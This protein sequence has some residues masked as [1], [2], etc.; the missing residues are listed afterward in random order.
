MKTKKIIFILSLIPFG[1]FAQ[2]GYTIQGKIP[3]VLKQPTKIFLEYRDDTTH[4]L[5]STVLDNGNFIFK[6]HLSSPSAVTLTV[7][8]NP[9]EPLY[10]QKDGLYFY[11]ENSD[12]SIVSPDS[13]KD[14]IVKGSQTNDDDIVLHKI[15]RPY[16]Q[17]ADSITKVYYTLTPEQRK[18]S[19]FKANAGK[20]M[21]I[22]QH[23][24]DSATRKFI[25]SHLNSYVSLEAFKE[26][27]LAYNFN[28]DTA[29]PK[30]DKFSTTLKES[31]LGKKIQT[32]INKNKATMMGRIAPDF[33][34][35]DTLGNLVRLSD[36]RG[37]YVLLDFW[38]SWCHPCRAENPNLIAAYKK[39]KDDNFTILSVSLDEAKTRSAWVNAVRYDSLPW[40]QI[41]ELTGFKSKAAVLYAVEAIPVNFL[42]DPSGKIIAR[43]LRGEG[44]DE[45]LSTLF[46]K[47]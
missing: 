11:I 45:K 46:I 7:Q 27:E 16:R 38:A 37:H 3:Y 32:I 18:D 9:N 36:F 28:P 41:S 4:V 10:K 47:K 24:Y 40:T 8:N 25:Y 43:N 13:L 6:G 20:I 2:K 14:A 31:S 42:L 22:T 19:A 23:D 1:G 17:V 34:E 35:K 26:V 15:Q 21:A 39:Y 33:A 29:Q 30:F 5:D 12:I 44:L